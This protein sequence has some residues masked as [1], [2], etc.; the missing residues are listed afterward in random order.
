MNVCTV[1]AMYSM[2]RVFTM[3][4]LCVLLLCVYCM[5][6]MKILRVVDHMMDVKFL[7]II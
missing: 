6:Y 1:C 2:N 5:W 4:E 3:S 7:E